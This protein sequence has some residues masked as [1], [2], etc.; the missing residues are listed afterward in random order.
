M[1]NHKVRKGG[2]NATMVIAEAESLAAMVG[3]TPSLGR[4]LC[5]PEKEGVLGRKRCGMKKRSCFTKKKT[6]CI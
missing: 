6:I 5:W 2:G 4:G 1:G 3:G